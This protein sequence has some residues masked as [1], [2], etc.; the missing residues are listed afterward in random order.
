VRV[1]VRAFEAGPECATPLFDADVVHG[2]PA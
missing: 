2:T 1:R